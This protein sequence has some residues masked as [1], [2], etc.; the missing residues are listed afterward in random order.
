MCGAPATSGRR[1]TTYGRCAARVDLARVGH[2]AADR[3]AQVHRRPRLRAP[4]RVELAGH[5][6]EAVDHAGYRA[7][8]TC[9]PL[10]RMP[11]GVRLGLVAQRV[12]LGGDD[13]RRGSPD[14]S[15]SRSGEAS[16]SAPSA[17]SAR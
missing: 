3:G 11:Y 17:G 1:N 5:A 12:V 6:E 7:M 4:A 10:C 9:T 13:Q 8:I 15:G 14:R 2:R 16:G